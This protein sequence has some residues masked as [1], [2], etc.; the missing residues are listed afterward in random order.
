MAVGRSQ[1]QDATPVWM[2]DSTGAASPSGSAAEP[3]YVA[4][5]A[6]TAG[7][8]RSGTA[9]GTT[10]TVAAANTSRR[11]LDFQNTSDTAMRIS[12]ITA[13]PASAVYGYQ[14]PAGQAFSAATNQTIT[15]YCAATGKTYQATEV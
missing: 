8:D 13:T 1:S 15:G 9:A 2:V 11:R 4:T 5:P 10:F 14:V 7:T 12:E 6:L 3:M